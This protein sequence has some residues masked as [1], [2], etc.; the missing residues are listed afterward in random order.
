MDERSEKKHL[1]VGVKSLQNFKRTAKGM[2]P[3]NPQLTN[4]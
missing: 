2:N 4:V 1:T 3:P